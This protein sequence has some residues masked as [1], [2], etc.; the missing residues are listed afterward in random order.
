VEPAVDIKLGAEAGLHDLVL[1]R[2]AVPARF[3][4]ALSIEGVLRSLGVRGELALGPAKQGI[5]LDADLAGLQAGPLA[6]YLPPGIR[7]TLADGRFRAALEASIAPAAEGGVALSV[8]VPE[9]QYREGESTEPFVLVDRFR[10]DVPRIDV[11]GG[12]VAIGEISLEGLESSLRRAADGAIH[13]FGFAIE[14][15]P[16]LAADPASTAPK[17]EEASVPSTRVPSGASSAVA[18]TPPAAEATPAAPAVRTLAAKLPHITLGKLDLNLRRVSVL[19]ESG[20]PAEP[21]VVEGLRLRNVEPL[22]L[23][24][25]DPETR[26]A[27]HFEVSGRL[28]PIAESLQ[29]DLRA[30]PFGGEP[31]VAVDVKLGG[32]SGEGVLA[33]QPRLRE[34]LDGSELKGGSA[35]WS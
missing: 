11:E 24:G 3:E 18:S 32:L 5:R 26:P 27:L 35:H 22:D 34:L 14:P 1:G 33:I 12:V 29:V 4:A 16:S 2:K 10:L 31:E 13:A 19:D 23:L 6:V 15:A 17:S 8:Q 28:R 20:G 9:L 25:E 7:S 30:L 21:L